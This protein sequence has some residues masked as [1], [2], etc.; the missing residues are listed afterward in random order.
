MEKILTV[1]CFTDMHNQQAMLDY[2]THLRTSF[3][4][5]NKLAVE[6]FGKA[7]IVLIGGDNVSDYPHWDKSCA[8]PKKNFLD[9]KQKIH[10]CACNKHQTTHTEY[11]NIFG[12]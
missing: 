7:D 6:E 4:Q 8:L 5:A 11:E 2:P 9:I 10:K 1:F 3:I 12:I